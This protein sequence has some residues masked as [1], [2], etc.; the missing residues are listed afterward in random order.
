MGTIFATR[1][2]NMET[3]AN[4][5]D[6]AP[7][8]WQ[9]VRRAVVVVDLVESVRLLQRQE[10]AAIASW[11]AFVHEVRGEVLPRH[12]GRLVK[13]LGDGMLLV[14][15]DARE[16]AAMA[17]ELHRRIGRHGVLPA[18]GVPQPLRL[19]CGLHLAEVVEDALDVYGAGVNLA[20]RLAAAAEPG[21]SLASDELAVGLTDGLD[22]SLEDLGELF[23]KHLDGPVRAWRL[24]PLD[25]PSRPESRCHVDDDLRPRVAVMALTAR[26]AEPDAAALGDL[27][28]DELT[29][30]LSRCPEWR[31]ISKLSS[32]ALSGREMS[33][34]QV[35]AALGAD[36]F[37]AGS[38]LPVGQGVRVDLQL[39]HGRHGEVLWAASEMASTAALLAGAD[40][41]MDTC[42]DGITRAIF[43]HGLR[44]VA[45][46]P[47]PQVASHELMLGA[48]ALMHRARRPDFER[49]WR[50]IEHLQE[51]HPRSP[52]PFAWAAK[53]H[54]LRVVQGWSDAPERDGQR[55]LQAGRRALDIDSSAA[56]PLAMQGLVHAYL[57][58]DF[59]AARQCYDDA[60]ELNPSESLALL[61]RGTMHAFL[62][63]GEPAYRQTQQA[64]ALS[65]LDPL[66]YF[67][68]S[69]ASS[70]AI[71]AG[72]YAE[73]I[74]LATR[75]LRANRLHLSTYRALAI[76]Q[77]LAGQHEE[78][79]RT[80]DELQCHEP[81][82]SVE[83]F[84]QRFPGRELAPDYTRFLAEALAAAG[85]PP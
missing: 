24:Q 40:S 70:S 69:L 51:R 10:D 80:V 18:D 33:A 42:V 49:A 76:A 79:R 11:R 78:A 6:G 44:V 64:L 9:R 59:A 3:L 7:L 83:R 34:A 58:H 43:G 23:L 71:A 32:A 2:A 52:Q 81:G 26:S 19:R 20:A 14:M 31:V 37:V 63:E 66:R 56:L 75:S 16:A 67:Y 25:V 48:I 36:Y 73:A 1:L 50:I 55:A 21:D 35:S 72:R 61:L 22:A 4:G 65:P 17:F 54:V 84:M 8:G 13:S 46:L 57:R 53:W 30:A 45:G 12:G 77:S 74:D 38:V 62:G 29:T 85:L 28:A 68:L 41:L 60:L 82:F 39:V 27:I 5:T 15:D 47:L